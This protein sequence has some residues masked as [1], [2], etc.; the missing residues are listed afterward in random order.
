SSTP[1]SPSFR[2]AHVRRS[3][4][5]G[6]RATE[7]MAPRRTTGWTVRT[8]TSASAPSRPAI[9]PAATRPSSFD[10]VTS[11]PGRSRSE[12]RACRESSSESVTCW[13]GSNDRTCSAKKWGAVMGRAG[14]TLE[15]LA[16][17]APEAIALAQPLLA[18]FGQALQ[19]GPLL[20]RLRLRRLHL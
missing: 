9:T 14:L 7:R 4:F 1:S 18:K 3:P 20:L 6:A 16:D 12:R 13:P 17:L 8:S 19:Q 2:T 11:W 5:G 15:Q 10:T